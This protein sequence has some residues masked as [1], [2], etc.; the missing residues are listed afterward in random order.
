MLLKQK[1]T[2]IRQLQK[3][4]TATRNLQSSLEPLPVKDKRCLDSLKLTIAFLEKQIKHIEEE[5]VHTAENVF[6]KRLKAITSIR[7]IG[8][9]LAMALI[10]A[11]GGFTC[12][13][14]AKQLSRYIGI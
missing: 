11:T 7:G 5:L 12:F 13:D 14:N 6:E 10:I 4:L 3:Q 8:I 1:R 2:V 9:T